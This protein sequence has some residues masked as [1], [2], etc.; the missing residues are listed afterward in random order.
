MSSNVAT[1]YLFPGQ[2]SQSVGMGRDLAA[3]TDARALWEEADD[4]LGYSLS[5]I[6]WEGPD[7]ELQRTE[8]AQPALLVASL[9]T[10][11]VLASR[12]V[13]SDAPA[14]V[15]GH[16]LG[17]YTAL[18]AAGSLT[19]ADALRLV[20]LR[21]ELMAAEGDRVGGAMAAVMGLSADLVGSISEEEG[22]DVANRNSPEQTVVSGEVGAVARVVERLRGAGAR[23]V[24]PLPVSGAFHSRLMRPLADRFAQAV[25]DVSLSSPRILVISNVSAQPLRDEA[26]IRREL[27]E[28]LYSPV[29]WVRT[30]E[31]LHTHGV[32]R[33]IEVGPG[34]VLT[35]LVRRT[36]PGAEAIASDSLLP[37]AVG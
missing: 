9:A 14:Y 22:V 33:Y 30:L 26:E 10:L 29:E 5:K 2:G 32:T 4:T 11:R 18:V 23:R 19:F 21:G 31:Y 17:E 34:K 28:Q 37:A 3:E 16:S 12:V 27:V 25:A 8:N 24:V 35:G 7:A 15:A 20:R 6:A 13:L 1:A 36:L